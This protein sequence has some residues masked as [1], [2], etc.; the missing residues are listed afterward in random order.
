MSEIRGK[1]KDY[2]EYTEKGKLKPRRNQTLF[3][4][5]SARFYAPMAPIIRGHSLVPPGILNGFRRKPPIRGQ[6]LWDLV[7]T[8][9]DMTGIPVPSPQGDRS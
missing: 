3:I 6:S 4:F 2:A 8:A 7:T 1:T 5:L 9:L